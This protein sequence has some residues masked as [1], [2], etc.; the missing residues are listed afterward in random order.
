MSSAAL[1]RQS[2]KHT[3]ARLSS[4]P[5]F[6]LRLCATHRISYFQL[7]PALIQQKRHKQWK[8]GTK[9]ESEITTGSTGARFFHRHVLHDVLRAGSHPFFMRNGKEQ[10]QTECLDHRNIS[11]LT[12]HHVF[13]SWSSVQRARTSG[14]GVF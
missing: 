9:N 8:R 2:R 12:A 3:L 5:A 7:P 1:K 6:H 11:W 13:Y 4:L 10:L 14:N